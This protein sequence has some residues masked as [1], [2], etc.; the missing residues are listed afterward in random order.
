MTVRLPDFARSAV[1]L[2]L[3]TACAAAQKAIEPG[4]RQGIDAGNRAWI[5]GMRRGEAKPIAGTY[6]EDATDCSA[7]GECVQGRAKIERQIQERIEKLGRA[8]SASVRSKGSV[9]QGDFVYEWGEAEASFAN[10]DRIAGRYLTVWRRQGGRG[11]EI[12]RN[13][14]IPPDGTPQQ[15]L[16]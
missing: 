9:Q 1:L 8:V 10:G 4:A 14:K 2:M 13:L 7:T 12:F 15:R 11:W 5:E 3:V 6:A 16:P